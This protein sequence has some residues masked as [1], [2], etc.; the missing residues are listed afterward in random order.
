MRLV[1]GTRV[2]KLMGFFTLYAVF[3]YYQGYM[4]PAA[5]H[6]NDARRQLLSAQSERPSPAPER[7]RKTA[8]GSQA[9]VAVATPAGAG[10]AASVEPR[11]VDDAAGWDA[12]VVM[13]GSADV[14]VAPVVEQN[15]SNTSPPTSRLASMQGRER[16]TNATPSAA[17]SPSSDPGGA[18]RDASGGTDTDDF[19]APQ[20]A[21]LSL[22]EQQALQARTRRQPACPDAITPSM[23]NEYNYLRLQAMGCA[24]TFSY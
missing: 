21:P 4:M 22:R 5:K 17:V 15:A 14:Y 7:F 9:R 24:P 19:S 8:S 1:S 18:E 11:A 13:A 16:S 12:T 2:A 20:T 10:R 6:P 3:F 23:I